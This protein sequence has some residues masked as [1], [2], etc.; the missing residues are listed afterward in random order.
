[1][2]III[3]LSLVMLRASGQETNLTVTMTGN[4]NCQ[5]IWTIMNVYI[6]LLAQI[7][8]TFHFHLFLWIQHAHKTLNVRMEEHV[9]M[10]NAFVIVNLED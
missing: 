7:W 6:F 1:M 4:I 10:V 3:I 8:V 9:Q 5:F 2:R